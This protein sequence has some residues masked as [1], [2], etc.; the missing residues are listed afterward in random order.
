M[1]LARRSVRSSVSMRD[2][3]TRRLLFAEP[4]VLAGIAASIGSIDDAYDNALVETAIGLFNAEAI[5]VGSPFRS[6]PLRTIDD[7]DYPTMEWVD[8]YNNRR[9]HSV[10]DYVPSEEYESTYYAHFQT[11]QPA[12]SQS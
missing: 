4:L 12:M 5:G 3:N 8:W 9:V 1:P 7:V 6:C 2:L 10:L 11:S